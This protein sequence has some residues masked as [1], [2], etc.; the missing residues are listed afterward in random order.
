[1][2]AEGTGPDPNVS[3]SSN[4]AEPIFLKPVSDASKPTGDR[5]PF[6]AGGRPHG[7]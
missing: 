1:M 5:A 2:M 3:K 7:A 4:Y 6:L